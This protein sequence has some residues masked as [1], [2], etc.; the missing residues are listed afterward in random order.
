MSIDL[1]QMA[2]PLVDLMSAWNRGSEHQGFSAAI[3]PLIV[4]ASSI[5]N[6]NPALQES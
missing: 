4:I 6:R 1:S 5:W 3:L 2:R